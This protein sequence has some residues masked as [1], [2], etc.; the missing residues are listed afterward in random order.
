MNG[1]LTIDLEGRNLSDTEQTPLDGLYNKVTKATKPVVFFNYKT[2]DNAPEGIP[3]YASI[4]SPA[5][6]GD[7]V[8]M[9]YNPIDGSVIPV[10]VNEND[11]ITIQSE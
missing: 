11:T 2:G 10:F 1:Y 4:L 6:G 9:I 5:A 3:F 7:V 8:A